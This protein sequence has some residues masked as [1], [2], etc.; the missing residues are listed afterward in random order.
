MGGLIFFIVFILFLAV[1]LS[2]FTVDQKSNAI[3]ELFG[4]FSRISRPG[5]N[6]KIPFFEKV[7]GR[8]NM[9]VQQLDVD[10]E[11]KTKDNVFVR[12][13]VS[14][15]Y[16]VLEDK[17]YDA[18]YS[19]DNP[20]S[21]ITAF[22]FD[23]VRAQVPT[24]ILDDVFERKD[25]IA[26]AVKTD[27]SE[28]MNQF[29]YDIVKA[30]VTDIEPNSKVK[31]AMNEINAADRMRV[32]ATAKAEADK[33]MQVTRAEAEAE[34]T[35]LKGVGI[36]RQRKAIIDGLKDSVEDFQNAIEGTSSTEIMN[37]VMATQYMD[38]LEQMGKNGGT[39]TIMIPHSPSAVN[40][41]MEQ[42][43]NAM[44]QADMVK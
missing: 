42:M 1:I 7:A 23:T 21:Q 33:I 32:A 9:K 18:F 44:I 25:D 2:V 3:L 26:I 6:F 41:I 20:E 19:L 17:V 43:R 24:I 28:V 14:V 15:Q 11:T 38:M 36:A 31:Q 16:F 37:I 30:L 4:K 10:V 34:A 8:I 29:G 5:L 27:L 39:N 22:I 35:A 12:V 13:V 40:D